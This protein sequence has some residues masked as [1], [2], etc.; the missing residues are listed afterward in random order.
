ME[1]LECNNDYFININ[2]GLQDRIFPL[3]QGESPNI[4]LMLEQVTPYKILWEFKEALCQFYPPSM[5]LWKRY[6]M[7]YVE[8]QY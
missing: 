7:S 6:C 4:V 8:K 1:V 2:I 5:G 3:N